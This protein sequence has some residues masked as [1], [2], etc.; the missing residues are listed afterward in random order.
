[1][2]TRLARRV[3]EGGGAGEVEAAHEDAGVAAERARRGDAEP[4]R[5]EAPAAPRAAEGADALLAQ[6]VHG[7]VIVAAG[8]EQPLLA[9]EYH[10]EIGRQV[11]SGAALVHRL[12]SEHDAQAVPVAVRR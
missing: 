8:G 1:R 10:G 9:L 11:A 6:L 7:T 4:A 12:D 5:H 2:G 3:L